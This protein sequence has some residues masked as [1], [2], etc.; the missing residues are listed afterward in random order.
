[1]NKQGIKDTKE[2]LALGAALTRV[3]FEA[4]RND[5]VIDIKDLPLVITTLPTITPALDGVSNILAEIKDLDQQELKELI[6]YTKEQFSGT[7]EDQA[8]DTIIDVL[9][10]AKHAHN[11]WARYKD[12]SDPILDELPEEPSVELT[13]ELPQ[14]N[15]EE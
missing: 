3:V 11:I 8:L 4:K 2:V 10:I 7:V 6:D 12:V 15:E 14:E 9:N 1:M 5:G 13:P